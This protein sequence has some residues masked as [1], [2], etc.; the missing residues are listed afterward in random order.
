[1]WVS[2][3]HKHR[4]KFRWHLNWYLNFNSRPMFLS[5]Q[6]G[7]RQASAA[8]VW[9]YW[10]ELLAWTLRQRQSLLGSLHSLECLPANFNVCINDIDVIDNHFFTARF[11]RLGRLC[12]LVTDGNL[13]LQDLEKVWPVFITHKLDVFN[14]CCFIRCILCIFAVSQMKGS[15]K[16]KNHRLSAIVS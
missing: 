12:Y 7:L 2:M 5:F 15:R 4:E 16:G 1:M 9:L 10:Q 8:V 11:H 13:C 3:I 14:Q 6:M